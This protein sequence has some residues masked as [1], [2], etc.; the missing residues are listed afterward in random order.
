SVVGD[1][2]MRDTAVEIPGQRVLGVTPR[3]V[4]L[5]GTFDVVQTYWT[6]HGL[7]GVEEFDG[8]PSPEYPRAPP[9]KVVRVLD[10]RVHP[11]ATSRRHAMGRVADEKHPLDPVPRRDLRSKRECASCFEYQR[12]RSADRR[13]QQV[14][15]IAIVEVD[16]PRLIRTPLTRQP[17]P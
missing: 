10:R 7:V 5:S 3:A 12:G 14:D 8:G 1:P 9:A 6:A 15:E 2:A 13:R 16:H 17:P 4:G 11:G